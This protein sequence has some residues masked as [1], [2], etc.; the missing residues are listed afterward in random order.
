MWQQEK[1]KWEKLEAYFQR[2]QDEVARQR[3]RD[4]TATEAA[5]ALQ[6]ALQAEMA[7]LRQR[8]QDAQEAAAPTAASSSC[9]TLELRAKIQDLEAELCAGTSQV[10]VLHQNKKLGSRNHSG[11][12]LF[13]PMLLQ[14]T[15]GIWRRG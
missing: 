11:L 5:E 2:L 1:L 9:L 6:R 8:L 10:E 13:H 3:S 12:G 15:L 14:N 4:H 7:Q